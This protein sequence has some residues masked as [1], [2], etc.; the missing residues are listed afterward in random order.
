MRI[1]YIAAGAG[2]MY[3]GACAR[4]VT[5]ITRLIS[6]GHDV[7]VVPLYTPLRLD[8]GTKLPT[9]P[10]FYGGINVFLQQLF[11]VFRRVPGF[12]VR[13]LDRPSVLR[14][15]SK[16]T[17]KTRP[18]DL[19]AMT[20]SVLSGHDG[21]QRKELARL[22]RYLEGE[23]K[24]DLINITNYLLSGIAPEIKKRLGVPI[25]CTLQ[26]EE[27]FVDGIPEP[28]RSRALDLIRRH[29]S[30]I[31]LYLAPGESYA[32]RMAEFLAVPAEKI[33][34]AR[35]GIDVNAFKPAPEHPKKPFTVGYLS[36]ISPVKGLDIL[37][38][39]LSIL[40]NDQGRDIRLRVAG[41]IMNEEYWASI[42]RTISD[43]GLTDRFEH[44]GEPDFDGKVEFLKACS[45]FS[46]PS[47]IGESR[48]M[49]VMEAMACGVPVVVPDMGVFPE[50]LSL[51]N[52]GLTFKSGDA[53][54]L[55]AAIAQVVDDPASA[56]AMG[57]SAAEGIARHYSAEQMAERVLEEYGRLLA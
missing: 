39:A 12:L 7:Q 24:P 37:V 2:G 49:A 57:R 6:R 48:G 42:T 13:W 55:A 21:H 10:I 33:R 40:V 46:V 8:A 44:I 53:A 27:S 32:A 26:V 30:A 14:W 43:K 4:D 5:L 3:C 29:T 11:P 1:I 15:A 34:V 16:S 22:M 28:H 45:V 25:V 41:R 47:R 56:A 50:L 17:V 23:A 36:V 18:Q 54:S 52:G 51:T 9:T 35:P 38:E 20:V 31:D 19:G